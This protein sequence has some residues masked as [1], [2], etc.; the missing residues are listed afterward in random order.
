[1][2][3]LQSSF[4][5]I[6]GRKPGMRGYIVTQNEC[7]LSVQHITKTYPGVIA[8]ND[9]SIDFM[10]GEVHALVGEN[11]AGKSTL[12]KVISGGIE[13]DEGSFTISGK[14]FKKIT[15]S[16]SQKCG[17]QI[18][19]QELNLVPTLSITENIFLGSF[20]GNGITVYKEQMCRKTAEYF[21]RYGI[22]GLDPNTLVEELTVA[23]MQLVEII[24]AVS[25]NVEILILDEPTSPLTTYETEI[26]FRIIDD[27][28]KQGKTIIYISHRM[29]EIY[30]ICD[31]ITVLRDGQKIETMPAAEIP[32]AELIKLMVGRELNETYPQR[33][34]KVG[35]TVLETRDL[36]GN[37]LKNVNL[38]LSKGEILGLAG[39]V[40]AGR[41]ELVRL[42]Y[43]ADPIDSGEI[44]IN[45]KKVSIKSTE[46]AAELGIALV[47]ED[48][49]LQGVL[50]EQSIRDNVSLPSL[51]KISSFSVINRKKESSLVEEHVR[52]LRVK[53]P[54]VHQLVKN[55]SGGNQ[56]KVIIAKWIASSAKILIF[57]EPT[58]GIDV[59]AKQEIY[60]L[61]NRLT[62]NGVS[63]IMVSSEMEEMI[64]MSDRI[65]VLH[66]GR[67]VGEIEDRS[68]FTQERIMDYACTK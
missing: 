24:K 34:V 47:P 58:R 53:T 48:R 55:L 60:H 18:V 4:L 33:T 26:L 14:E 61:M 11:G 65:M 45:G 23:Q 41:T 56:Q 27:L 64:G 43:G 6:L 54:S 63:I 39:L 3:S 31:T 66:E 37:G 62:E 52:E 21:E 12:M 29:G 1:M 10:R 44:F 28:K 49:K 9:V 36:C 17:I 68:E 2:G 19:H 59:G 20:L 7:L 25:R 22:I 35:E 51:K 46:K 8:L 50:L 16:V 15:P 38:H 13:P 30:R 32:R 57:D 42:I 5:K 67:V 40:G